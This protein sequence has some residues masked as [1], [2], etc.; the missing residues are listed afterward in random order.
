[1]SDPFLVADLLIKL[2]EIYDTHQRKELDLA[3]AGIGIDLDTSVHLE[4]VPENDIDWQVKELALEMC[5]LAVLPWCMTINEK[6]VRESCFSRVN[7][8]G[9][10]YFIA[11]SLYR[12]AVVEVHITVDGVKTGGVMTG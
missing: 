9:D 1:M 6:L 4:I 7:I 3:L 2:K 12:P 10:W 5:G 8:F 11:A